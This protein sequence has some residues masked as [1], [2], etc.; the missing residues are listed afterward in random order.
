MTQIS[1]LYENDFFVVYIAGM[2]ASG[3]TTL[4]QK[5]KKEIK[6]SDIVSLDTF[7]RDS[8]YKSSELLGGN[9]D[10]PNQIDMDEAVKTIQKI[11]KNKGGSVVLPKYSF[12]TG[13]RNGFKTYSLGRLKAL[14]VEGLYAIDLAENVNFDNSLKIFVE[15]PKIE[16]VMRRMIRDLKRTDMS[17][18]EILKTETVA[19]EMW[20]MYGEKQREKAD[21]IYVSDYRILQDKGK[22][23]YQVKISE[24]EFK[25]KKPKIFDKL[26]N[27]KMEKIEDIV[28]DEIIG[29]DKIELR[30][31]MYW[32]KD[33][34]KKSEISYR[35]RNKKIVKKYSIELSPSS[36]NSFLL[37]TTVLGLEKKVFQRTIRKVVLDRTYKLYEDK[38]IVEIESK[39]E[40]SLSEFLNYSTVSFDSYYSLD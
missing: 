29:K 13:R 3:K 18:E 21:K 32:R 10:H 36:Y 9:F 7:Y 19:V 6:N 15:A 11:A 20:K 38:G 14:I 39:T 34:P 30:L 24:S 27:S 35:K 1:K 26:K 17:L 2:T 40:N 22:R 5:I 33:I 16:I 37:L 12:K 31:R 28:A 8:T 23:T 25:S 4:A